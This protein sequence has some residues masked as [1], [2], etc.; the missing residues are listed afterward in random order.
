MFETGLSYV[1]ADFH[2]H[3]RKDKEFSFSGEDNSFVKDYVSALKNAHIGVGVI[4]NHNKFDKDEYKAIRKAAKKEG[5]FILPGV[6]LTV[7]EGANGIHTLIVFNPDEWLSNGDNHIHT[8]LTSAFAT[9]S[10]PENRNTK[11][12]YDLKSTLEALEAYNRDYFVIFAHVDQGSGLFN[13]CKGGLL[14]SLSG[15]A[16]FRKRVLG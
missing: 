11:C 1:R 14:E 9:I 6:E 2:L 5:I 3:T 8:F 13:E 15:I 10:N 4:T 12:T 16:S 7:K